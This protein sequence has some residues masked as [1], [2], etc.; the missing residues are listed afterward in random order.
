LKAGE[1]ER[2]TYLELLL[3]DEGDGGLA[4]QC[5]FL[6]L[7]FCFSFTSPLFLL[8]S[9]CLLFIYFFI[10]LVPSVSI[11]SCSSWSLS[12]LSVLVHFSSM[13]F[14]IICLW[15][16]LSLWLLS[17]CLGFSGFVFVGWINNLRW[18]EVEVP[19]YW[20][21]VTSLSVFSMSLVFFYP[22]WPR[23]THLTRDPNTWP[24]RWPGRVSKLWFYS[25]QI[26]NRL[27]SNQINLESVFNLININFYRN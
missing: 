8:F 9:A 26:K 7:Y 25:F 13:F 27:I 1:R 20:R 16:S 5:Y 12:V 21:K 3:K 6:P 19:F 14:C 11:C 24:D 2:K 18:G 17:V 15:F 23:L 22:G 4:N 10:S